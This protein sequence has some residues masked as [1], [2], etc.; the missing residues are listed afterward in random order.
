MQQTGDD[1]YLHADGHRLGQAYLKLQKRAVSSSYVVVSG[2]TVKFASGP[3][4][5]S[6]ALR[7]A[8]AMGTAIKIT[9]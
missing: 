9:L 8:L 7:C 4:K 5:I 6:L 1:I 3:R 2:H